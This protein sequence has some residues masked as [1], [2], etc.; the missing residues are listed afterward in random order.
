VQKRLEEAGERR[1][2]GRGAGDVEAFDHLFRFFGGPMGVH[3]LW[4]QVG[5]GEDMGYGDSRG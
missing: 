4:K 2:R 3:E 1:G 5:L